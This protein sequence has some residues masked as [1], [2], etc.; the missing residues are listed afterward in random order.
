MRLLR[1]ASI[2]LLA[3]WLLASANEAFARRSGGSFSGR[4]GFRSAPSRSP[5]GSYRPSSGGG[6]NVII[7]PGFG[8]GMGYGVGGFGGMSSL[9]MLGMLGLA[10]FYV[11]RSF[12]NA[13][14]RGGGMQGAYGSYGGD[15]DQDVRLDRAY[16]Y[17]LQLGFGR[18]ARGLQDRLSRFAEEGDTSSE[19][20]LASLLSQTSL[21][22]TREKDSIRY[23]GVLT[24]GPLPL[25][26]GESR[27]NSLA[28]A[29]RSRF[30][31]ERVRSADGKVRK[32][33]EVLP[34]SAEVLEFIVVTVIV[35]TRQPLGTWKDVADHEQVQSVVTALGAVAPQDLLGLEVIWTPADPNDSLTQNDLFA[36]YP[37]LKSI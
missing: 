35:A 1:W 4:G 9:L 13:A 33:A 6:S 15:Y 22:L 11:Y 7:M 29:E 30:D 3:L 23:A 8:W 14:R 16:V 28:L 20:G 18:S 27:M 25:S 24:E 31:V 32:A 12:R 2:S 5:S 37:N 19:S 36:S 21:E 26:Q 17:K 34:E 10:G